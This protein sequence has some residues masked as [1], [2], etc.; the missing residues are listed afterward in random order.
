MNPV[1][2]KGSTAARRIEYSETPAKR[3]S[4]KTQWRR[5]AGQLRELAKMFRTEGMSAMKKQ[6]ENLLDGISPISSRRPRVGKCG[7]CGAVTEASKR[8]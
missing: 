4:G 2:P 7:L 8:Q 1:R 3:A 5:V 6:I